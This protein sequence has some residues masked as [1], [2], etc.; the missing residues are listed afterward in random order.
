VTIRDGDYGDLAGAGL[1]IIAPGH[2]ELLVV[3]DGEFRLQAGSG[4]TGGWV[5]VPSE[6]PSAGVS[7]P[8]QLG[9]LRR[10]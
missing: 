9:R 8:T 1:A 10:T 2:A 7:L 6:A 4:C 5:D 3:I